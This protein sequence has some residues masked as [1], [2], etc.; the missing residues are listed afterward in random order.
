[1]GKQA[2]AHVRRALAERLTALAPEAR[3]R[4]ELARAVCIDGSQP[5]RG[6]RRSRNDLDGAAIGH[7]GPRAGRPCPQRAARGVHPGVILCRRPRRRVHDERKA[8]ELGCER[9]IARESALQR[10]RGV[11]IVTKLTPG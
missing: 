5:L 9:G 2:G 10:R 8:P 11:H 4:M 6:A 7:C 3:Q 1:M